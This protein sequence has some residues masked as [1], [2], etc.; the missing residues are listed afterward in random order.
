M[1]AAVGGGVEEKVQFLFKLWLRRG[2]SEHYETVMSRLLDLTPVMFNVI[3]MCKKYI[4]VLKH[5]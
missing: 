5:S 1:T 2:A 4:N 3:K